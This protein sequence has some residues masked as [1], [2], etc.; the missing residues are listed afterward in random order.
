MS[1]FQLN[2]TF[3][4]RIYAMACINQFFHFRAAITSYCVYNFGEVNEILLD[5]VNS[6]LEQR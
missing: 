3:V 2:I 5:I 1:D 6:S 4:T